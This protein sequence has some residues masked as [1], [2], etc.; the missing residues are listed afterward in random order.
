MDHLTYNKSE[1]KFIERF[2]Y[3]SG[4]RSYGSIPELTAIRL[5]RESEMPE[6]ARSVFD[7]RFETAYINEYGEPR[8][9]VAGSR[10]HVIFGRDGSVYVSMEYS[11][12]SVF[13]NRPALIIELI[14]H[15]FY[16]GHSLNG[17]TEMLD[18]QLMTPNQAFSDI[19]WFVNRHEQLCL[20]QNW[21][22]T[23]GR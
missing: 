13:L 21:S 3:V 15:A 12:T 10:G 1:E 6:Q 23:V 4:I 20:M 22:T 16:G 7:P 9:I 8:I 5:A 17:I 18:S 11:Q 2:D 14:E 19:R